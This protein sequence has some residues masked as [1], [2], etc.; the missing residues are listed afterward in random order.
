M[1]A[2]C[3]FLP[4]LYPVCLPRRTVPDLYWNENKAIRRGNSI[5][6]GRRWEK[7]ESGNWTC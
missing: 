1:S 2:M 5:Q 4:L 3:A 7:R 6:K